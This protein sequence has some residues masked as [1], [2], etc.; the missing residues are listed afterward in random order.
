MICKWRG[1]ASYIPKDIF[2]G[3]PIPMFS[4]LKSKLKSTEYNLESFCSIEDKHSVLDIVFLDQFRKQR[5]YENSCNC[6]K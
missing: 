6:L 1:T 2:D 3:I 5:L 4:V